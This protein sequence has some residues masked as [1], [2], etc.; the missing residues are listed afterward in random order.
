MRVWSAVL[1]CL[2]LASCGGPER[3]PPTA[4]SPTPSA[5]PAP[6]PV[7]TPSP[8]TKYVIS[9]TVRDGQGKPVDAAKV[10]V[11]S[12][13]KTGSAFVSQTDARGFY[14]GELPSGSYRASVQKAGFQPISRDVTLSDNSTLDFTINPGVFIRGTVSEMNV[15]PLN[16]ATVE[17][18]SGPDTGRR[19]V[20][21]PGV[22]GT[23]SLGY[24]RPGDF[25]VRARMTG[26]DTVDRLIHGVDDTTV[27]FILQWSH[28][29]CL[30]SVTP[31]AFDRLPS[32]GTTGMVTVAA[33]PARIWTVT[34]D[35][36][37]M[38]I[39]SPSSHK[40][41]GQLNFRV[42]PHPVGA[43][44]KRNGALKIRCS[45]SEGQNVWISQ[46]PDCQVRLEATAETP[47]VFS[48]A[49]GQGSLKVRT[50]TPGCFWE[51][52]SESDWMYTVGISSWS[53]DPGV[54]I[55][56]IVRPN[57]TGSDRTGRLVVGETVW[58]IR[59]QG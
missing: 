6:P 43:I 2:L 9:G 48:R 20:T 49:G 22:P 42:L 1:A 44:Q 4:P 52:R 39:L 21:G 37:W 45:D 38:E 10:S 12:Y 32:S 55:S 50:G 58:D 8:A 56:F 31:V 53:G 57:T 19:T 16:G 30:N 11:V 24:V 14:A 27:D 54:N 17:I 59:Q 15:G 3:E 28:G 29:S 47:L 40:G 13:S 18:V 25:I 23:Y 7:P 36:P 41:P 34:P 33:N 5:T 46:L 26:Y 51:F 35:A